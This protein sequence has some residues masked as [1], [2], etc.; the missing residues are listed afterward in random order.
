MQTFSIDADNNISVFASP[1][2]AA[3]ASTTPFDSFSNR[4]DLAD[5]I[6][7]WPTERIVAT[8]NSLPGVTPVKCFKTSNV[9]ATKIWERIRELSEA[10]QPEAEAEKPEAAGEA[11]GRERGRCPCTV[12]QGRAREGQGGQEGHFCQSTQRQAG[13]QGCG[14]GNPAQWLED[15]ASRRHAPAEEWSHH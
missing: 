2:E 15:R 1:E 9:A 13:R 14:S 10:A 8:W 12:R 5:L 7:A 3:A 4:Q 6:A 11:E